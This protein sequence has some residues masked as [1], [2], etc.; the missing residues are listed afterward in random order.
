M[1]EQ[2]IGHKKTETRDDSPLSEPPS[3]QHVNDEV[4]NGEEEEEIQESDQAENVEPT[5][6]PEERLQSLEEALDQEKIKSEQNRNDYLRA[7]ADMDNLRKRTQK[8]KEN[9]RKFAVE[10]FARDLLAVADNVERALSAIQAESPPPD[11]GEKNHDPLIAG[12]EMIQAEMLRTFK[13]HG[14]EEMM[15][16]KQPFDPNFHQAITNI[17]S[18]DVESGIVAQVLQKGYTLNGRLLRPA[19]VNVAK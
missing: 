18:D 3:V 10:G 6:T 8:E 2:V 12:V 5:I 9:S 13:K 4:K 19:M 17:E 15:A 14:V 16:E 1:E 7:M 11:E